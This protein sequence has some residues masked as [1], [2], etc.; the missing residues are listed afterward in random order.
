A[1]GVIHQKMSSP[2]DRQGVAVAARRAA[3]SLGSVG[4]ILAAENADLHQFD[5]LLDALLHPND[6]RDDLTWD[7]ATQMF[8]GLAAAVNARSDRNLSR[9]DSRF[10]QQV[11]DIANLLRFPGGAKNDN[12]FDSPSNFD[13]VQVRQA[14]RNLDL[15]SPK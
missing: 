8:L 11:R 6:N 13:P 9:K 7:R 1:I 5:S 10:Q 15:G 12:P 14:F 4:K 3:A 2:I